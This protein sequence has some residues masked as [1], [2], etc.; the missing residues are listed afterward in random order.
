MMQKADGDISKSPLTHPAFFWHEV[1]VKN[2][3]EFFS[4]PDSFRHAMNAVFA[5]DSLVIHIYA[6]DSLANENESD[7]KKRLSEEVTDYGLVR[8]VADAH[9]HPS[10]NRTGVQ[11]S[12]L[13]QLALQSLEYGVER[14]G[15]GKFGSPPQ[16]VI[17]TESDV[18]GLSAVV[19]NCF[20]KLK[21]KFIDV[22]DKN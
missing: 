17:Q 19:L 2:C 8:D 5:L 20:K 15:E 13:D 6:F 7:F 22:K 11:V 10:L 21:E 3:N 14:F 1:V 18:R 4:Y 9:R 12:S 16:L